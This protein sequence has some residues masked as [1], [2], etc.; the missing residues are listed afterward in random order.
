MDLALAAALAL[1]TLIGPTESVRANWCGDAKTTG[2]LRTDGPL[3]YDGTP[4]W[5]QEPIAAASWDVRMGSM[6]DVE[7]I[8]TFRVADRGGGLGSGYPMPHIDIA[9]WT[10]SE[11]YALTGVRRICVRRPRT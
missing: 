11:A 10:R 7:N 2:Y 4:T 3:T 8:G 9:V 5:T 1:A 6:V